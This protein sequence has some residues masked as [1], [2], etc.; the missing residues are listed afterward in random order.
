MKKWFCPVCEL[1]FDNDLIIIK[2]HIAEDHE[3][4]E[5]LK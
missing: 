1:L 5:D 4:L 3:D 2:N